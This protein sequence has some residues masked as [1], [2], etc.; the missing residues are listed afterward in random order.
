MKKYHSLIRSLHLYLG[1]FIIPF[2]LIFAISVLIFNH[3]A[4]INRVNPVKTLPVVKTKLN[5]ITYE[6]DNLE[7]AKDILKEL[8][9]MGEINF[10]SR[11]DHFISF[12]VNTPGL[13]IFIKV[14][15]HTDSVFISPKYEGPLRATTFLHSMPGP[16]NVK[17]RGNSDFI[18]AWRVLADAVV[19]L[20]L[21]LTVSGVLLWYFI[22]SERNAGLYAIGLGLL[23]FTCIL[24]FIF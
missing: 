4:F 16:H 21:F 10:I 22:K 14:D 12:P 7:T 3:Q 18:K 9:I 23:F 11:N 5:R 24:F 13:R 6:G 2:V 19:Y 8:N 15:I 20:L 17:V 1:L